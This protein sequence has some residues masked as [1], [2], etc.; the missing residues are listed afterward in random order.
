MEKAHGQGVILKGVILKG[1]G[2]TENYKGNVFY[3]YNYDCSLWSE[4][5]R[6]R[7]ADV[8]MAT[9]QLQVCKKVNFFT[10]EL[11]DQ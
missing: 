7:D 2:E 3:C 9:G 4:R 6:Q 8:P 5:E 1:V 11:Q 10:C